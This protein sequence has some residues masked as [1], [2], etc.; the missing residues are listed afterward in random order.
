MNQRTGKPKAEVTAEPAGPAL[1]L[2]DRRVTADW[3]AE[4]LARVRA[5]ILEA[6]P[7]VGEERKWK[8]PSNGMAGVPVWSHRGVVCTGETYKQ[9]V[10]LTFA[11]GASLPDPSSLFNAGLEGDTRRAIDIREGEEIDAAAFKALVAAAV[12]LN[13]SKAARPA[14]AGPAELLSGGN[15]QTPK[16]DGDAPVRAYIAAMPGWK[17]GIGRRLD[18]LIVRAVPG[19]RKAVRWNSPLY[20]VE[21]RGWFLG[22]RCLTKSVKVTFFAGTSL[23]PVPAG[24]TPKSRE[25]RWVDIYE[26]D[27]FDEARMTAWVEQAAAAP[28][29]IP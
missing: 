9:V 17:E 13:A 4:T 15:P 1:P 26:G 27:E 22:V 8:K 21:G 24:G 18:D 12:A 2:A 19:V 7:G 23:R 14:E 10:K 6:D 20:G 11:K 29:W 28:G 16:G 25:A 3:R 5:L